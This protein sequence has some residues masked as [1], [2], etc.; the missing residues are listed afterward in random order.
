ML[1]RY[2]KYYTNGRCF[3]TRKLPH[4]EETTQ[5]SDTRHYS[6][7]EH[8]SSFNVRL[9]ESNKLETTLFSVT[10]YCVCDNLLDCHFLVTVHK[11]PGF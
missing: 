6:L 9:V 8:P 4:T 2:E 5:C 7:R 11:K 3:N 1:S 10:N